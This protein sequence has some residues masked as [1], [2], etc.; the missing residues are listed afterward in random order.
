MKHQL[1]ESH[2][3]GQDARAAARASRDSHAHT[4]LSKQRE[5]ILRHELKSKIASQQGDRSRKPR[6]DS[7]PKKK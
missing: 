2:G 5:A 4:N 1:P 7:G 6:D 3:C